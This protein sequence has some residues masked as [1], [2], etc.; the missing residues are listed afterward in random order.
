MNSNAQVC[1]NCR[2]HRSDG[3]RLANYNAIAS[4]YKF[5]ECYSSLSFKDKLKVIIIGHYLTLK[6]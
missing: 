1:K 3:G 2:F 4:V 6:V 5:G